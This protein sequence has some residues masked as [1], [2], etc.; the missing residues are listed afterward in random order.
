MEN[1]SDS[2]TGQGSLSFFHPNY[3]V[4]SDGK[5]FVFLR[6]FVSDLQVVVIHD[7]KPGLKARTDAASG[8]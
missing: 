2:P 5:S 6:S 7:W 8:R 4:T 1:V 3:D